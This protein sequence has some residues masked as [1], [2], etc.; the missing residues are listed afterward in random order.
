MV[1]A[2]NAGMMT[3][4]A[5]GA[6]PIGQTRN[7][8]MVFLLGCVCF[9][10]M[11]WQGFVMLGELK[12]YL[13]KDEIN[14]IHLFIP[15]LNLLLIL[16]LPGWVLEAKQR[17]GVPNPQVTNILFYFF[18]HSYFLPKDLNEVWNPNGQPQ[19]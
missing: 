2:Q 12:A 15:I 5:G 7:P 10:Y 11:F 17:A 13:N 1:P 9:L 8:M 3:Y 6:G 18:F 4:P 19:S 14:P 16:K